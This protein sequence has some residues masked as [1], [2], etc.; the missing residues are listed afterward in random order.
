MKKKVSLIA[1]LAIFVACSFTSCQKEIDELTG[2]TIVIK[3]DGTTSNGSRF[4]GIDDQNFYLDYVKY[5]VVQGHLVVSGYEGAGFDGI[6]KIPSGITHKGNSYEVLGIG[7]RAFAGCTNLTSITIPNSVTSIGE[8]GFSGC[9]SLTSIVIPRTIT[10]IGNS[11][12]SSCHNMTTIIVK[13]GNSKYDSRNNCNAIIE[14]ESNTL[15]AGCQKTIIPETVTRIK[16]Y[17]FYGCKNL[18]SITIPESV[19]YIEKKAFNFCNNLTSIHC[20]GKTPPVLDGDNF[21]LDDVSVF[22][23]GYHNYPIYYNATLYVPKSYFYTYTYADV[24]GR[25]KHIEEE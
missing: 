4:V 11:A 6:A 7:D 14:T 1:L 2:K 13:E 25:F 12:F 21:F 5:S 24:W 23:G 16:Q 10:S 15:I 20:K 8:Y 18:S 17:A 3:D 22:I 19:K 9:T